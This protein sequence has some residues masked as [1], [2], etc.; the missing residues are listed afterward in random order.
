MLPSSALP[1]GWAEEFSCPWVVNLGPQII[2]F[3]VFREC[4]LGIINLL[5]SLGGMWVSCVHCFIVLGACLMLPLPGFVAK[6]AGLVLWLSKPAF[7]S[8][9]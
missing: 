2:V 6:Q 7:L 8:N 3:Y 1:T 9:H 4:I 5:S